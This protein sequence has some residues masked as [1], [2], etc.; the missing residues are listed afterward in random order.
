MIL[1]VKRAG[2]RLTAAS[3]AAALLAAGLFIGVAQPAQASGGVQVFVGYADNLRA[4]PMHFPTPWNG[5]PNV[6]FEGCSSSSCVFDGGAARVVNNSGGSVTVDSI[7]LHFSTCTYD[8]WPHNVTL[9]AGKE[10][11]IAQTT[12]GGDNGCTPGNG[13]MDSSDIGK[14]GAPWAGNCTQSGVKPT[15]D[16]TIDGTTTSFTDSTQVLNTDGVDGALCPPFNGNES[17]QWTPIGSQPCPGAVLSLAP[18][19][20]THNVGDTATVTA[21]FTCNAQQAHPLQNASVTFD[22]TGTNSLSGH[23][24]TDKN[25]HA[26]FSYSSVNV[27][28]DTVNAS[29]SNPAGTIPS[30]N[31]VQVIWVAP[32]APGGGAFVIGDKNSAIGTKVTFWGARWSHLNSLSGGRA[33]A[34]FKGF[35]QQP[36]VPTCGASWTSRPGNSSHPPHG[37]LPAF[38]AVIVS[39]K[40]TKHGNKITGDILHIVVVKTNHGYRP[41]PGHKGTGTV[42]SE[43]C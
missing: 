5:S 41:N 25:G 27:G 42:V 1:S 10:M 39:S 7:V 43:V 3:S 24:T 33:P 32:F 2:A 15:V 29:V 18:P 23:G 4:N 9:A 20:Q 21:T 22:V 16:V 14:N 11:I 31:T 36:K 19:T 28:T 40:V 12:S 34:S 17:T 26:A 38:M 37:P 6:T 8:I 30:K 35:A 13:H